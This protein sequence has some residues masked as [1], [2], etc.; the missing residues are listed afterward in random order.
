M[1]ERVRLL[2]SVRYD[3]DHWNALTRTPALGVDTGL[4]IR[5]SGAFALQVHAQPGFI[6][7]GWQSGASASK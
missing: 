6:G 3:P 4:Q 5:I 1:S 2:A 7:V